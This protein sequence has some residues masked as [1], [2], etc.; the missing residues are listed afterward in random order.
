MKGMIDI[1][2]HILPGLDDGVQ[3]IEE[4]LRMCELASEDGISTVVATPHHLNGVYQNSRETVLRATQALNTAVRDRGLEIE[5]LPGSDT[6]LDARVLDELEGESVMTINDNRR[7]LLL[8][9]PR[10]TSFDHVKKMIFGMKLM[11]VTPVISHPERNSTIMEDTGLLYELIGI[12][13]LVQITAGSLTGGFGKA[14]KRNALLLLESNMAHIIATDAHNASTRPPLLSRAVE[15]V[16]GEVGPE[17]ARMMVLDTP[18]AVING[19]APR[20]KKPIKKKKSTLFS[21]FGRR[22]PKNT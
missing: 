7:F 19:T 17:E 2:S 10:F 4:A 6:H 11:G 13:A 20:I 15:L 8:E 1:H 22:R 12:G 21:L 3:G 18:E 5:V 9:L 16:S 14:T